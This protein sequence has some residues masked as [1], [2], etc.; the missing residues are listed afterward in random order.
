MDP[1]LNNWGLYK[2]MEKDLWTE[3]DTQRSRQCEDRGRH[4][5][6]AA[7][8]HMP[9]N[10]KSHQKLGERQGRIFS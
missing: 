9:K 5:N 3:R 1:K 4:W 6:Y 7:T 10:A 8:C 2:Q